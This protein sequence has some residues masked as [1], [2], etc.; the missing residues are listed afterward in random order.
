MVFDD[1]FAELRESFRTRL[2]S[3]RIHFVA[4]SSALVNAVGVPT[5]VLNDLRNRAHRLSGTSA[6]FELV[7]IARAARALELAVDAALVSP[8]HDTA[9]CIC[10]ALDALVNLIESLGSQAPS[11]RTSMAQ[12]LP[13]SAK[14]ALHG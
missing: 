14:R 10:T 11:M 3:E 6:I 2:G 4:L 1:G 9:A 13:R 8:A 12:P 5:Q 7:D